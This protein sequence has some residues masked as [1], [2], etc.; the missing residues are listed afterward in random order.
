LELTNI[1]LQPINVTMPPVMGDELRRRRH[2][3]HRQSGRSWHVDETYKVQSRWCYLH[4]DENLPDTMLSATR[5]MAAATAFF[6]SAR[7]T[8]GFRPDWVMTDRHGSYPQ[9]DPKH[10]GQEGP[11]QDQRLLKQPALNRTIGASKP[12]SDVCPTSR[13]TTRW[14]PSVAS[15]ANFVISSVR[16]AITTRP[17]QSRPVA[18][19]FAKGAR[20]AL[21]IMQHT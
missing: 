20:M 5:D 6:C 9:G 11:A 17:S 4:Q 12:G 18:P 14:P 10:P 21:N 1:R 16:A 3:R 2:G 15:M 19:D 13:T 7:A 8:M